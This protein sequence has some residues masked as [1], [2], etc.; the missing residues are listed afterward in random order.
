M[1]HGKDAIL[2]KCD[3]GNR[4][5]PGLDGGLCPDVLTRSVHSSPI[6]GDVSHSGEKGKRNTTLRV[7]TELK[8]WNLGLL[9]AK[10]VN[11]TMWMGARADRGFHHSFWQGVGQATTCLATGLSCLCSRSK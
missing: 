11:I 7:L 1:E 3:I 2:A 10:E 4:S 9:P 5:E 8:Y 6:A